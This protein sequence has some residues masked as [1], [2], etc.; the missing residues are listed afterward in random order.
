MMLEESEENYFDGDYRAAT[1]HVEEAYKW[2]KNN[3]RQ[4]A[5]TGVDH[6]LVE[7]MVAGLQAEI[8]HAKGEY[9]MARGR[10]AHAE[11]TLKARIP[12]YTTRGMFPEVLWQ[13]QAF[14]N[15]VRGD[16]SRPL[17][18]YGLADDPA[19]PEKVRQFMV[20]RTDASDAVRAYQ[21]ADSILGKPMAVQGNDM[22]RLNRLHGRLFTNLGWVRILKRGEPTKD[23]VSDAKVFLERA[24]TS[25]AKN[26][27]WKQYVKNQGFDM[28][29]VP[30]KEIEKLELAPERRVQV[31][32]L[33]SQALQDWCSM[34]MLRIEL[35]AF[36]ELADPVL[37]GDLATTTEQHYDRLV[38]FLKAQYSATHPRLQVVRLS[39]GRWLLVAARIPG[40]AKATQVSLLR[41][42]LH[43]MAAIS[44]LAADEMLQRDIVE[45]AAIRSARN[46]GG[47]E[48]GLP[49]PELGRLAKREAELC[50]KIEALQ[51][52]SK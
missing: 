19:L 15:F 3:K 8:C 34:Q 40:V 28:T 43:E 38:S 13:F 51:V 16:V 18:D 46:A 25:F 50:E 14:L 1:R 27:F 26:E 49:E 33:F 29:L 4:M 32:R 7:S 2:L 52:A 44:S 47:G 37:V 9:S 30:Y 42:C 24:E 11:R 39:R 31:K 48:G 22:Y 45:L 20:A 21:T 41:D 12:A 23:D 10:L 6:S 17:P 36:D 35:T 5:M